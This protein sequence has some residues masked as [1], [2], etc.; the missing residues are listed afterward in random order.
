M[1]KEVEVEEAATFISL[2]NGKGERTLFS[3]LFS[4]PPFSFDRVRAG[5]GGGRRE[6]G[7]RKG[8]LVGME[9]EESPIVAT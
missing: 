2:H 8:C 3:L 5:G 6:E 7:K 9:E 4:Y 1:V